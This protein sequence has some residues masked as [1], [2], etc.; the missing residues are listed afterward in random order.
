MVLMWQRFSNLK[1]TGQR[2]Q[3][4]LVRL[5]SRRNNVPVFFTGEKRIGENSE[6]VEYDE[7]SESMKSLPGSENGQAGQSTASKE[8]GKNGSS[9]K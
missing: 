7:E 2:C 1:Y 5:T 6:A 9:S 3:Q 8:V 4:E